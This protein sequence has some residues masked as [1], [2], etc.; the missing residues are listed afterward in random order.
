MSRILSYQ[1]LE[2]WKKSM[3]LTVFIYEISKGFPKDGIYGL[4]SQ[5]RR[6]SCS[7][8]LNIAEGYGRKSTKNYI[9]FLRISRGS[10]MELETYILMSEKLK[11]LE[12]KNSKQALAQLEEIMKMLHG[13]IKSLRLKSDEAVPNSLFLTPKS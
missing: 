4:T 13:L 1:D 12:T 10:L 2:V 8:P 9:H 7:V 5:M 3:T 6:A 11:Y